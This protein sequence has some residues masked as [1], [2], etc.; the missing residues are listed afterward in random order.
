MEDRLAVAE[1]AA[2]AAGALLREKLGT[3]IGIRSKDLRTN[4]VTEADTESEALI[5][6]I[7]AEQFPG[8]AVLGEESGSRGDPARGC[9]IVDP[10]DGTTNYAHGY[11]CFCASIA[12]ARGE[13]VELGVVYDPMADE[14]Y[15]AVRGGGSDCNGIRLHVS[16]CPQLEDALLCTGFPA[17]RVD[18]PLANL[19][20][21]T[22]FLHLGQAI[23]R[24]GSAAL[25]L[26]YV[27]CGR[28]D[29]FWEPGLHAWDVAAGSLIVEE[30]SGRLS[31]Y[32][33]R[34]LRLDAGQI[35]A[36][37]GHIHGEMVAVLHRYM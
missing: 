19:P 11:R 10:L 7:I 17:H 1:R 25:D 36:T 23:R 26:C 14:L 22:E 29:G 20:P 16:D 37:N 33:G 27:A 2:R 30:A 5:R 8:E 6:S 13:Q 32:G 18:D 28:F 3:N 4:L 21:F 35:I 15:K 9:W 34:P 31:D 12:F 24:D